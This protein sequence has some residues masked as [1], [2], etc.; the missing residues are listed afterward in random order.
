MDQE[1]AYLG[2]VGDTDSYQMAEGKLSLL[3][4]DGKVLAR[5]KVWLVPDGL[6]TDV[7]ENMVYRSEFTEDGTAPLANGEYREPAAPN[8]ASEVVVMLAGPTGYGDL[9]GEDAAAVILATNAG[10]SGT[11]MDL[12][13]VKKE[14]SEPVN[15]AITLVGDRA[16]IQNVEIVADEIAVS[17]ITHG[18]DDPMCCPTQ[19]VEARYRLEGDQLILMPE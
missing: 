16:R 8:S 9:D 13:V 14:N 6:G 5:F 15:V 18:P 10:G 2:A 12:A 17:M 3:G 4:A 11:F 19:E 7:L 1:Q